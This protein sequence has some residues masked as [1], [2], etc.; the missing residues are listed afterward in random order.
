MDVL[1]II[2]LVGATIGLL[3]VWLEM[4]ASMWLWPVSI[5]MSA[6]LHLHFATGWHLR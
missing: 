1:Q 4:R 6:T 2:E 3:Y 5:V